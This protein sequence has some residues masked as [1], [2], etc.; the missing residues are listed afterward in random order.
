MS[1]S[2]YLSAI[3]EHKFLPRFPAVREVLMAIG[4]WRIDRVCNK[5]KYPYYCCQNCGAD[6]SHWDIKESDGYG[7][8]DVCFWKLNPYDNKTEWE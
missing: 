6:L 1:I 4:Y 2:E 5:Q 7:T 3:V 8:C